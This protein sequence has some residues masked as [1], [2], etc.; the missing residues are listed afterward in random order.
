[1]VEYPGASVVIIG[2]FSG[3]S[4]PGPMAVLLIRLCG[5]KDD[6]GCAIDAGNF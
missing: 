4:I 1:M 6:L 5:A 2:Q 3:F